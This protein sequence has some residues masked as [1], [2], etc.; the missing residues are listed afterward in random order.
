MDHYDTFIKVMDL[1]G[2]LNAPVSNYTSTEKSPNCIFYYYFFWSFLAGQIHYLLSW[3]K[4]RDDIHEGE[5][6]KG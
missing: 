5:Y 3:K 6:E 1:F 2:S 4:H